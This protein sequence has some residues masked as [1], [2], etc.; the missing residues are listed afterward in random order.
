ML[1]Q[2]PYRAARR[3]RENRENP[4]RLTVYLPQAELARI[5]GWGIAAGKNSRS[6]TVRALIN[7]SLETQEKQ[8]GSG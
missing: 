8:T 6:E 5:D 4:Q 2:T 1:K 3:E 7:K